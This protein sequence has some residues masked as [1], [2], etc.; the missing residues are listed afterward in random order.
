[1]APFVIMYLLASV[2]CTYRAY[3]IGE[4]YY[5]GKKSVIAIACVVDFIIGPLAIPFML[6]FKV[7][8]FLLPHTN[9]RKTY[10]K[11]PSSR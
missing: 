6:M 4:R 11:I 3:K 5:H 1:M 7:F 10:G 2:I 8:D 9:R